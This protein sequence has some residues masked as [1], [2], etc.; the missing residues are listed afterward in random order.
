MTV[1]EWIFS[2][3][4]SSVNFKLF[5]VTGACTSESSLPLGGWK[6]DL[7]LQFLRSVN[8]LPLATQ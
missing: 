1:L 3:L 4:D 7:M 5:V 6:T 2:V 8:T